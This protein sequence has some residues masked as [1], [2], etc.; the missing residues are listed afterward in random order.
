MRRSH[1]IALLMVFITLGNLACSKSNSAASLSEVDKYKLYDA[2]TT[3]NDKEQIKQVI[4]KLGIG[5]GESTIPDHEFFVKFIDWK[6]TDESRQF[7]L[8]VLTPD[9]AR[10]YLDK[11]LPK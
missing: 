4:K 9:K 3:I 1:I 11:H 7:G 5:N 10:D 8:E 6:G 2:A